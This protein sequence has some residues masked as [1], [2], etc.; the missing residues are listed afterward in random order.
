MHGL[1]PS[2]SLLS[3]ALILSL[4]G[5]AGA[6]TPT[7]I[8]PVAAVSGLGNSNNNIPFSWTPTAYQQVHSASSFANSTPTLVTRMRLR[9]GAGFANR[10]SATIDVE[11]YMASSPNDSNAATGNFA[12]N[13]TGTEVNV[14]TRKMVTLPNVPDNSWAVPPF[15]FDA[16]FP[17]LAGHVSWRAIVWGNSNGNAIFTYPLDAWWNLGASALSGAGCRSANGTNTATH[18]ATIWSPGSTPFVFTGNSYVV[19]GGLPA[20]LTI[21]TSA[22]SWGGIPLPFDMTPLGAPGCFIRNSIFTTFGGVT[23]ANASGS[24]VINVP[25]P[26]DPSLEGA[27]FHSQFLFIE[28]GANAL[29]VFASGGLTNTIGRDHGMTRIY[30]AGNPMATGGTVGRM[31]GMAIGLN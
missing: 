27:V 15:P 23:Q 11:L 16:P 5:P 29:G 14:L 2:T 28:S 31:F 19:A 20:I 8:S 12:N 3:T 30:A 6:Q 1:F 25:L 4:A 18:T 13:V 10:P 24:A 21:G 22:T 9:M 17:Y 7:H 26:A